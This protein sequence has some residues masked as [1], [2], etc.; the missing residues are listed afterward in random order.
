MIKTTKILIILIIFAFALANLSFAQQ[1]IQVPENLEEAKEMG[2]KALETGKR[3][4]P[5]ILE[6]IWKE[7]ILPVWQKMYDW[8]E[9]NIWSKIKDFFQNEVIPR[10]KG[11][12]EKRKPIIEQEFEKEKQEMKEELPE[13][14]KSL[15]E[16]LKDLWE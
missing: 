16:R 9:V 15:W 10:F 14:T 8:F 7:D 12:Y 2:E 5:D 3:N 4:L 13:V 6:R 1:T 11:E